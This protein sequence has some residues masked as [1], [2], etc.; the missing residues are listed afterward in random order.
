M[1]PAE[2]KVCPNCGYNCWP[3][4][5]KC[6]KCNQDITDVRPEVLKPGGETG[7]LFEGD[8]NEA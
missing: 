3:G 5:T 1:M 4:R 6:P 7:N 2:M 8:K